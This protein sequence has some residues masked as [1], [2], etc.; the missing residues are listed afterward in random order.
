ML[1]HDTKLRCD[2]VDLYYTLYGNKRPVC[3]PI[4]ELAGVMKP[5][6]IHAPSPAGP[7]AK[8][9]KT[10]PPVRGNIEP[11]KPN[12]PITIK[13]EAADVIVLDNNIG[14]DMEI[15]VEDKN[16]IIKVNQ[17]IFYRYRY[18]IMYFQE[19]PIEIKDDPIQIIPKP[20]VPKQEYF[21]DNSVSLPGIMGQSGPIGFEPGM[22]KTKD[23]QKH[24]K[25]DPASK[26]R[27]KLGQVRL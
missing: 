22:F 20:I 13:T 3:L 10:L 9:I 7:E 15:I 19:E 2:L 25:T 12:S 23:E 11:T 4:P 14:I 27:N 6:K 17:S 16:K 8:R 18:Y 24:N 26:V 1:S 21:S 5:Q